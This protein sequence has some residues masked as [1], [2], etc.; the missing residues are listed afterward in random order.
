MPDC[1]NMRVC[2]PVHNPAAAG[3]QPQGQEPEGQQPERMHD[4]PPAAPFRRPAAANG[5]PRSALRQPSGPRAV[6]REEQRL[7]WMDMLLQLWRMTMMEKARLM[8]RMVMNVVFAIWVIDPDWPP[9][10]VVHLVPHRDG[11]GIY[12]LITSD[13]VLTSK[14]TLGGR[15]DD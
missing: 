2:G 6:R 15:M 11:S 8:C 9:D 14:G 13:V 3:Q 12:H 7:S 4:E 5:P 10:C 1:G